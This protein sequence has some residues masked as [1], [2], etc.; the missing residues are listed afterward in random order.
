MQNT[1][2]LDNL[3]L[4]P[5]LS[6]LLFFTHFTYVTNLSPL[7]TFL[8]PSPPLLLLLPPRST[9]ILLLPFGP[10]P[11][12]I[13]LHQ[14]LKLSRPTPPAY[15]SIA[16]SPV[17]AAAFSTG[18]LATTLDPAIPPRVQ[19]TYRRKKTHCITSPSCC[20]RLLQHTFN[21][22]AANPSV[23]DKT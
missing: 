2:L 8:S 22:F 21:V 7:L 16:H 3:S 14:L 12:A 23:D 18:A 9:L 1:Y 15:R 10:C 5:H 11:A 4:P 13:P 20:P 17:S 6:L 19:T